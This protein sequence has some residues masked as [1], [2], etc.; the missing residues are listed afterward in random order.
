MRMEFRV[1]LIG[2]PLPRTVLGNTHDEAF[3]AAGLPIR[4]ERIDV[5]PVNLHRVMTSLIR[6]PDFLGAKIVVPYKQSSLAYCQELSPVA[7]GIGA[8]N[9]LVKRPS[10]LIY[11]DNTDV[12]AF[13][14]SL[15]GHGVEKVRTA[16]VLGAGGAARVALAGLRQLA[17]A[18]YMVGYRNPRR[19]TE[20]S[21]HFK[22]IRRQVN[23]F[24]LEELTEFF[25]WAEEAK[26]FAGKP[27]MP[28]LG[29]D[30]EQIHKEDDRVKRW[31][32]LVNATPVGQAP[33]TTKSL[34]T[35]VNF[36]R[37]FSRVLDMVAQPEET[38]LEQL[39][40]EDGIPVVHGFEI[41]KLQAEL[42][43][44]LWLREYRRHAGQEEASQWRRRPV[45]KRKPG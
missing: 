26:L 44:E 11:G 36:L 12:L 7:Q 17:C 1:C 3:A 27:S 43:R 45:I 35:S 25:R 28:R 14:R 6:E 33:N 38:Q 23:Y 19:P 9:T 18:R 37:C 40:M 34:I 30:L 42:S 13:I 22:G 21:S 29:D 16:L 5:P 15:G 2:H 32:L 39:A 10:G 4:Y 8:V 20:L 31:D 41:F 24:P